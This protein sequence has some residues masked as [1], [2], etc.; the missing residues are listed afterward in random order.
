[1]YVVGHTCDT[2]LIYDHSLF[3][4]WVRVGRVGRVGGNV[5]MIVIITIIVSTITISLCM[6]QQLSVRCVCSV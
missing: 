1:M 4:L 3:D 2:L 6:F 5:A